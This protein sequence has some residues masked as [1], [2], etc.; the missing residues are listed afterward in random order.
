MVIILTALPWIIALILGATV[1]GRDGHFN[2]P[3]KFEK[4]VIHEYD[5][6]GKYTYAYQNPDLR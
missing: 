1:A 6:T 3:R 5:P 4:G 2:P